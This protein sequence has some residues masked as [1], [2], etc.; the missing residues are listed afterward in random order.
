MR[1]WRWWLLLCVCLAGLLWGGS[2][3]GQAQS[4]LPWVTPFTPQRVLWVAPQGT[5]PGTLAEPASLAYVVKSARPGDLVWLLPGTYAGG[6]AL[7]MLRDG[8]AEAPIV[9]RACPAAHVV[10]D[11]G[12]A[13]AS[14]Y[15]W[16]WGLDM[17]NVTDP[18][19]VVGFIQTPDGPVKGGSALVNVKVPGTRLINN[20]VHD[21]VQSQSGIGGWDGGPGQVYY[22]NIVYGNG[23]NPETDRAPH[24]TYTQNNYA[25]DGY[26]Y[27]VHNIIL[28][29]AALCGEKCYNFHAHT[30]GA[31]TVS[32]Y[33]LFQNVMANGRLAIGGANANL[34]PSDHHVVLQNYFY[35]MG[36]IQ[37]GFRKPWQGLFAE[38]YVAR[39]SSATLTIWGAGETAFTPP[40]ATIVRDNTFVYQDNWH[41]LDLYSMTTTGLLGSAPLRPG[42]LIDDNYYGEDVRVK[43][44]VA[45]QTLSL[46]S[47]AAWTA[48]SQQDGNVLGFDG[49]SVV[50]PNP[51]ASVV[52]ALPNA[53]EP[54]RGHL[55]IYNWAGTAETLVD[56]SPILPPGSAFGLYDPQNL[57]GEPVLTGTFD[58]EPLAVPTPAE[59]QSYV[60]LPAV[61]DQAHVCD[62]DYARPG[63]AGYLVW[64]LLALAGSAVWAVARWLGGRG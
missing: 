50:G 18:G 2:R 40:G 22:G 17:T 25:A 55:A 9:Y 1:R 30:Q 53:Y 20:V 31:G 54:G 32:G 34:S 13:F 14:A 5:G 38:N 56:L 33:Y 24:G 63:L 43:Y 35:D 44:W 6:E 10:L 27:F 62:P 51:T 4:D 48:Q 64:P 42:D 7:Y 28:D 59:F 8:T 15:T 12:V 47:L 45:D 26:K 3:P 16:F 39:N 46:K 57:F 23:Q 19:E 21:A 29:H 60:V 41:Y 49:H 58:G 52:F 11:G 37:L 61:P 36:K